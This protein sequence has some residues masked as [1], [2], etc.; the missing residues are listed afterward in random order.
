MPSKHKLEPNPDPLKTVE[1]KSGIAPH[2]PKPMGP[3][4]RPLVEPT[5]ILKPTKPVP[6]VPEDPENKEDWTQDPSL[7]EQDRE[8]EKVKIRWELTAGLKKFLVEEDRSVKKIRNQGTQKIE[9]NVEDSSEKKTE[10]LEVLMSRGAMVISEMRPEQREIF[11]ETLLFY[12]RDAFK[13]E[14]EYGREPTS[15]NRKMLNKKKNSLKIYVNNT[16][17]MTLETQYEDNAKYWNERIGKLIPKISDDK[18]LFHKI[19]TEVFKKNNQLKKSKSARLNVFHSSEISGIIKTAISVQDDNTKPAESIF[20]QKYAELVALNLKID[21]ELLEYEKQ[22][23]YMK[24]AEKYIDMLA[25][26]GR[27]D[28]DKA[29]IRQSYEA[30]LEYISTA[31]ELT[32]YVYVLE[33][34]VA[35]TTQK[36]KPKTKTASDTSQATEEKLDLKKKTISIEST[37]KDPWYAFYRSVSEPSAADT[38]PPKSHL[39]SDKAQGG[40][41]KGR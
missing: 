35:D 11:S 30:P 24:Q 20:D 25:G 29:A 28:D 33:K 27:N 23:Q 10:D 40:R 2:D 36:L 5:S 34:E 6:V 3:A 39:N 4:G 14:T 17:P 41:T 1:Q 32:H 12:Y 18:L 16:L 7:A 38:R 9:I 13:A 21:A 22:D 15:E 26:M 19:A 31:V 37:P 8:P